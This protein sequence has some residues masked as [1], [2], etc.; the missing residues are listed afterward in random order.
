MFEKYIPRED[1]LPCRDTANNKEIQRDLSQ[2]VRNNFS[3]I[4]KDLII[5]Q[6]NLRH[7]RKKGKLNA[8]RKRIH[9]MV[10]AL[11]HT[12]ITSKDIYEDLV[13]NIELSNDQILDLLMISPL[14]TNTI[15]S[16]LLQPSI[17]TSLYL[18]KAILR[19][20]SCTLEAIS[21]F[22]DECPPEEEE[23]IALIKDPVFG[24][25]STLY[26]MIAEDVKVTEKIY[27]ALKSSVFFDPFLVRR[28]IDNDL[29]PL[30]TLRIMSEDPDI[31]TTQK[32]LISIKIEKKTWKNKKDS[33]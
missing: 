5:D 8:E 11:I 29:T 27:R 14:S 28:L 15:S 6:Q 17:T 25:K 19:H 30:K 3:T 1:D 16:L 7:I 9:I 23:I 21:T 33:V 2:A 24:G 13:K 12:V 20:E 31:S 22:L 18:F 26:S 32:P 10:D 4:V